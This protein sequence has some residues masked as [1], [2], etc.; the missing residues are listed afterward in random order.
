MWY[1]NAGHFARCGHRTIQWDSRCFGRSTGTVAEDFRVE[2]LPEDLAAVLDAEGIESAVLVC[3]SMGGWT[4]LPFACTF[5][6]RV[7]G[8]VL[9]GTRGG[10]EGHRGPLPVPAVSPI[11]ELGGGPLAKEFVRDHADQ[12]AAYFAIGALNGFSADESQLIFD[13]LFDLDNPNVREEQLAAITAPV[14]ILVGESDAVSLLPACLPASLRFLCDRTC[15]TGLLTRRAAAVSELPARGDAGVR[16]ADARSGPEDSAWLRSLT[17]LRGGA[18]VQLLS[19]G[20]CLE[21]GGTGPREVPRTRRVVRDWC[22]LTRRAVSG[23]HCIQRI[24]PAPL[25]FARPGGQQPRLPHQAQR[26]A[27]QTHDASPGTP[28]VPICW[29]A[30]LSCRS[31]AR[32]GRTRVEP[33]HVPVTTSGISERE[34]QTAESCGPSE[35]NKLVPPPA[36]SPGLL[37]V[38]QEGC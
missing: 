27:A 33:A 20:F 11:P 31:A 25:S 16:G 28:R 21:A 1:Q 9:S 30:S 17:I 29:L 3:Q 38:D 36:F 35:E 5:P 4:G 18:S 15:S 14:L 26:C 24:F 19:H 10:L 8:L 13:R 34:R 37:L 23:M 32:G 2:A 12:A 22:I 6:E 7:L